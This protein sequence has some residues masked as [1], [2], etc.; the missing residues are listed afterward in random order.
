MHAS[1]AKYLTLMDISVHTIKRYIIA[2]ASNSNAQGVW[3]V[4]LDQVNG[5]RNRSKHKI[6]PL[7]LQL[8]VNQAQRALASI[9]TCWLLVSIWG[10]LLI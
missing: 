1:L 3:R 9:Q 4:N 6:L 8:Q 10:A 2:I 5:T 7:R